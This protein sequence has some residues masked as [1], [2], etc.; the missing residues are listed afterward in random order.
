MYKQNKL[1]NSDGQT[2]GF[3]NPGHKNYDAF[4]GGTLPP[5]KLW[6]WK[7]CNRLQYHKHQEICILH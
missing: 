4:V 7:W 2:A 5:A 3:V 6:C 1:L